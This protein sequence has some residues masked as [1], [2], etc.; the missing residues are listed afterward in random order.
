[1]VTMSS[2]GNAWGSPL[3][4]VAAGGSRLWSDPGLA[5][6]LCK[7]HDK[8]HERCQ[9]MPGTA[10]WRL[11]SHISLQEHRHERLTAPHTS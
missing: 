2:C 7:R 5:F 4:N 9:L 6:M 1:M 8:N 11:Y 3:G 10:D